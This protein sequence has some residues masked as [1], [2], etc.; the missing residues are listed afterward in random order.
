[1]YQ[2]QMDQLSVYDFVSPLWDKLAGGNRWLE[3]ADRIDWAALEQRY[4]VHFGRAGKQAIPVRC[5]FGCLVIKR[6]L[7]VSDRQTVELIRESP[8]LQ[9]FLGLPAFT[10]TVPFSY[11]SMPTFRTR[12]PD[13]QIAHAAAQLRRCGR[14]R[15]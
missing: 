3:L 8:Y 12:I 1:M 6:A 10:D 5:A 2:K 13:R 14:G 9:Y 11:R 4:A 15:E 7:G